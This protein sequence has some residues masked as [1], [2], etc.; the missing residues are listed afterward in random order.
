MDVDIWSWYQLCIFGNYVAVQRLIRK[1][2][3]STA[4]FWH[5]TCPGSNFP[6]KDKNF[7][8][9][10]T[11]ICRHLGRLNPKNTLPSC[12]TGDISSH[13]H[14]PNTV[15]LICVRRAPLDVCLSIKGKKLLHSFSLHTLSYLQFCNGSSTSLRSLMTHM[16]VVK[17]WYCFTNEKLLADKFS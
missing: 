4:Y 7:K 12:Q 5:T 2:L 14:Y 6:L 15:S 3:T 10:V 17:Q 16:F 1:T 13:T 11:W 8:H 9:C